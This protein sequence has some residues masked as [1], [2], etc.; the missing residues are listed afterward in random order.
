MNLIRALLFV[1]D[2]VKGLDAVTKEKY[3]IDF[4]DIQPRILES[5]KAIGFF[6]PTGHDEDMKMFGDPDDWFSKQ[7]FGMCIQD[8]GI[9]EFCEEY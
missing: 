3:R 2:G 6:T 9:V 8:S 1:N 5:L 4:Y 7:P